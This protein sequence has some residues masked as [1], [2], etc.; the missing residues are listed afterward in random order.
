MLTWFKFQPLLTQIPLGLLGAVL[1]IVILVGGFR[2]GV[3]FLE[4][5]NLQ[6]LEIK[7]RVSL[8]IE[9]IKTA[10]QFLAGAFFL[11]GLYF[12]WANLVVS[13]EKFTTDLYVQAVKQ[14]GDDKLEVRL[15]GIY[16][17]ER[18]TR[19]SEKDHGPIMEF[20]T[21][22]VREKAPWPPPQKTKTR[23]KQLET[24]KPE[25]PGPG[26]K[27]PEEEEIRP[28]ADIQA[29]LTVI[30]RR[31]R[32]FGKGETQRLDLR[33]TDLRG[34]DLQNAHL[35]RAKLS[36]AHLERADLEEAHLE[37]AKLNFARLEGAD[38]R[39]AHLEGADLEE[40]HLD[41]AKLWGAHLERARLKGAYLKGARLEGADLR[42]AT[43]LTREQ[44]ESAI[45]DE[46]TRLPDY[47]QKPGADKPGQP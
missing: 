27:T 8:K 17:L 20:L 38:L 33:S 32:T 34:A 4:W 3:K 14:V 24:K 25:P 44:I 5:R 13:Q 36:R 16:A 39:G 6:T 35:E 11:V 31:S 40:A 21:A 47:L 37:R 41:K 19:G 15:G 42:E 7:E 2:W 1:L 22:Y 30:G 43:G 23:V 18:I 10:A 45:I 46:K 29:I 28:P 9:F 26:R 12:T